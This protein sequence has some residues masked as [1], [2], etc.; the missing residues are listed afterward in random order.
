MLRLFFHYLSLIS[1][2]NQKKKTCLYNFYPLKPHCYLV[3]FGFT[4]VYI[5]F[6]I[7]AKNIDCWYSLEPRRF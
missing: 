7:S 1:P 2:C 4:G 6:H 5:I 3:M